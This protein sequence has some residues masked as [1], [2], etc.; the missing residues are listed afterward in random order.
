MTLLE[1]DVEYAAGQPVK[2]VEA[3]SVN[4]IVPSESDKNVEDVTTKRSIPIVPTYIPLVKSDT[5]E[6]DQDPEGNLRENREA[7]SKTLPS[8]TE[9]T[10]ATTNNNIKQAIL[11][12][13]A[14]NADLKNRQRMFKIGQSIFRRPAPANASVTTLKETAT[15]T[16]RNAVVVDNVPDISAVSVSPIAA[17]VAPAAVEIQPARQVVIEQPIVTNQAQIV[18]A[19]TEESAVLRVPTTTSA[20]VIEQP[21]IISRT[22]E[23]SAIPAAVELPITQQIVVEQQQPRLVIPQPATSFFTI[24]TETIIQQQ[25]V[26][27]LV[28]EERVQQPPQQVFQ[29]VSVPAST[30]FIQQTPIIRTTQTTGHLEQFFTEF[31]V[32]GNVANTLQFIGNAGL[33]SYNR[34]FLF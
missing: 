25:P 9:A 2:K 31:P 21:A 11:N 30:T 6:D 23:V 16:I 28:F 24:P 32:N 7:V 19:V 12:A 34:N 13:R 15:E 26:R 14:A 4:S 33:T 29:I 8:S 3:A 10:S 27:H 22:T 5:E 17:R 20:T 18:Q 1:L